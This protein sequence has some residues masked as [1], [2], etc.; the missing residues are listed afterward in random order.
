MVAAK[1]KIMPPK[2]RATSSQ[3]GASRRTTRATSSATQQLDEPQT[4]V[5]PDVAN[6]TQPL[7]QTNIEETI[8]STL[9]NLLPRLLPSLFAN[10]SQ[11]N[12]LQTNALQTTALQ[13]TAL[14]TNALQP[15]ALGTSALQTSVPQNN[16]T[17][18]NIRVELPNVPNINLR[19]FNRNGD[20]LEFINEFKSASIIYKWSLDRQ[21]ELMNAYLTEGA[22]EFYKSLSPLEKLNIEAVYNGL[23]NKYFVIFCKS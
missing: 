1:N 17:Q 6:T 14:Q 10:A 7:N 21:L 19:P 23:I 20:I 18:T 16:T 13:T 3:T 2:R 5:R 22:S 4:I 9:N 12:A 8:R 11:T 15:N